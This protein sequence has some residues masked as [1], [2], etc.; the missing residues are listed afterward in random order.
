MIGL[1]KFEEVVE[2]SFRGGFFLFLG[3][4][5][6][7]IV[8]AVTS[9]VVA[10][11]LGPADYGLYIII[12]AVPGLLKTV[13]DV[14]ISPALTRFTAN[15]HAEGKDGEVERLI[16]TGITAKLILLSGVSIF[17]FLSSETIA[18][19]LL[20][21]P[22][23]GPLL[24]MAS[25]YFVGQ[26]L[27]ES[28]NSA[29]IGLDEAG[30][31]SF[32]MNVEA[33]TRGL[34][35]PLL[36]IVGLGVV[37]ALIGT[38]LG[39]VLAAGAGGALLL[40]FTLRD[41]KRNGGDDPPPSFFLGLKTMV[42]YGSPLYVSNLLI[43]LQGEI[44][45]ILL[46]LHASNASI[47]NYATAVNFSVFISMI[48]SPIVTILFPAFSKLSFDREGEAVEKLFKLSVKYTSLLVMPMALA[49]AT[50][51]KD[52]VFTLYGGGYPAAPLFLSLYMLNYLR[53]GA[54][55]FVI[56]ALLNGQGDTRT[57]FRIN[58]LSLVLIVSSSAVLIP[59]YGV[60]G[61]IAAVLFTHIVSMAYWLFKIKGNYGFTVD[62]SSSLRT[63]AA[64]VL[65]AV[66]VFLFLRLSLT[67]NP[68]IN[69]ICGGLLYLG[70]FLLFAPIVGA[71]GKEDIDDLDQLTGKIPL[72]RP[73]AKFVFGIE[74]KILESGITLS[75]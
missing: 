70:S 11:M 45:R 6:S 34:T 53:S 73:F 1:S 4:F 59:F 16:K 13:S 36:I 22:G 67:S 9:I 8:L 26:A 71:L 51:S 38:G 63:L 30:K 66:P 35:S 24:Q 23:A 3:M 5:S 2:A 48:S 31:S 65:S 58:L 28:I 60:I 72:L 18:S 69:T 43:G 54:G 10:R 12:L 42:S 40:F 44:Q 52:L 14:G 39:Y 49:M 20:N 56:G 32:L 7:T 64:S 29:L 41:L 55:Q 33:F 19:R 50:L 37:G 62:W 15:L 74:R 25:L 75:R 61:L 27:F 68:L 17:L 46:S 21:R 47:G 57:T